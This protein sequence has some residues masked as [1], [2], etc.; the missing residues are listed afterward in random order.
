MM[1]KTVVV[2]VRG[3]VNHNTYPQIVISA[4]FPLNRLPKAFVTQHWLA[5]RPSASNA[6][7]LSV[8]YNCQSTSKKLGYLRYPKHAFALDLSIGKEAILAHCDESTR[9]KI[10]RALR[11]GFSWDQETDIRSFIDFYNIFADTKEF[12]HLEEQN[13]LSLWPNMLVSKGLVNG[14]CTAMHA[15]LYDAA[16]SRCTLLYSCSHYRLHSDSKIRNQL[17]N[18]S[19]ALYL[20]DMSYFS[21]RGINSYDFGYF[22]KSKGLEQVNDFKNKFPCSRVDISTYVS[23]PYAVL[24]LVTTKKL[25]F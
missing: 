2:C 10:R 19:L 3:Q 14:N 8:Y 15:Y 1:L 9:Y 6:T 5:D 23:L 7:R 12:P 11:D 21:G 25:N 18:A 24:R 17:A 16:S 4:K 22:G 13:I 20:E